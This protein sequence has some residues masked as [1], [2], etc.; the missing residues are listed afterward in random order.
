MTDPNNTTAQ[1]QFAERVERRIKFLQALQNAGL[2]IYLP[3]EETARRHAFEQLARLT[4]RQ[5][6]LPQLSPA[7]LARAAEQFRTH[8]DAMQ[9]VLPHDVQYRNRI[10]RNW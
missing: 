9:G 8:I 7:D 5:R 2:G 1:A 3:A 10:R 4:A 6:E